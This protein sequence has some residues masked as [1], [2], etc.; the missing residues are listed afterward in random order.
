MT[1]ENLVFKNILDRL[2]SNNLNPEDNQT[3][4]NVE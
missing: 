2:E 1:E 4:V 3:N